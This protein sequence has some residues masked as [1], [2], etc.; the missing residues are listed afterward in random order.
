MHRGTIAVATHPLTLLTA[1]LGLNLYND[2]HGKPTMCAT[3]RKHVPWPLFCAGWAGV[4]LWLVPHYCR[5]LMR[6]LNKA[7]DSMS[8]SPA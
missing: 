1:A 8:S 4:T 7:V 5:P 2:R 3:T 6:Q